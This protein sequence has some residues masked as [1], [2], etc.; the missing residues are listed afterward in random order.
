MIKPY[1]HLN[2]DLSI[3]NI[4]SLILKI[5]KESKLMKYDELLN[6][7]I[8]LK[9]KDAKYIFLQTLMFLYL[10][11]KIEYVNDDDSIVFI[12]DKFLLEETA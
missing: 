1:K 3:I 2:L 7:I 6:R 8:Y 5:L 11:G 9:G 4:G 12:D 10:L